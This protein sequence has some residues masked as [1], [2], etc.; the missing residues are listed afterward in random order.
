MADNSFPQWRIE[1]EYLQS[2][3][4]DYGCLCNFNAVTN[5]R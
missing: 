4:C 1:A 2:R 3:N 5:L